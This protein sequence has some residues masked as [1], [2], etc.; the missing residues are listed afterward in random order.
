MESSTNENTQE[1]LKMKDEQISSL[2]TQNE[3]LKGEVERQQA[4]IDLLQAVLKI[5][6]TDLNLKNEQFESLYSNLNLNP[7]WHEAEL[8]I[9]RVGEEK[10][11]KEPCRESVEIVPSSDQPNFFLLL[12]RDVFFLIFGLLDPFTLCAAGGVS[13]EWH[14]RAKSHNLWKTLLFRNFSAPRGKQLNQRL[15]AMGGDWKSMYAERHEVAQNWKEGKPLVAALSGHSGTIT[16]LG[17]DDNRLISGSDD[18]SL[19]LW[20]INPPAPRSFQLMQQHHRQSRAI[21]R[22]HAFQGHGGPVWSLAF[23]NN[24]LVSGSYD[25]TIKVWNIRTGNCVNTLRGHTGWV[26]SLQLFGNHIIS[27][28]WDS[29]LKI[30]SLSDD[31]TGNCRQSLLGNAGDVIHCLKWDVDSG[32]VATGCRHLAVQMWDL[33]RGALVSS[34]MGHTKQ[35]YCVQFDQQRVVSGSGDHTIKVWDARSAHCVQTLAQHTNPV[36]TLQYDNEY[37]L[38]SGSYDKTLRVWDM[39]TGGCISTLEGHSSAVF[40][41]QFDHDR[42]ISGS[43]DRCIRIWNYNKFT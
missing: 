2:Q 40:S 6:K 12:P 30:W 42:I 29:T 19:I 37:K 41:L 39:R 16:S 18:G 17:F 20:Q 34:F 38:V 32:K 11:V 8:R 9:S 7:V 43:A 13:R 3:A 26:S 21:Q 5:V 14:Q 1:L 23:E 10:E 27:G 4:V 22:V 28:S 31:H 35:V 15:E 25:K 33:S 24:L 36:M